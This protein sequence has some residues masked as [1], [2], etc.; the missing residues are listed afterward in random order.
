MWAG[1][2]DKGTLTLREKLRAAL[3]LLLAYPRLMVRYLHA[4][5][6]DDVLVLYP[7]VFEMFVVIP[8]AAGRGARVS[9][10]LFISPWDTLV[11]DRRAQ[12]A[13]HPM[14]LLLLACEWLASRF[15]DR[16][17]LDTAAHAR[18]FEIAMGLDR[19][20]V[21]NVPL[22]T[23]PAR[24]P[25]R[26]GVARAAAGNPAR[27]FRSPIRLLFYGQ[28]IPL[29]GL[30]TI[31][32]AAAIVESR[33]VRAEWRLV[34][35]GQEQAS[36][37]AH[38]ARL[39]VKSV[40]QLGWVDPS[41]LPAMI[42]DADV[43]LGIFGTSDKARTVVPNKAYELAAAQMPFISGDTPAMRE[44]VPAGG[45]PWVLLVPPGDAAALADCV[46]RLVT[47]G[48]VPAA[49]PLPVIGPR[50]RLRSAALIAIGT[51]VTP[52]IIVTMAPAAS[53]SRAPKL[54]CNPRS[55]GDRRP[56]FRS[57]RRR[58]GLGAVTAVPPPPRD[59]SRG[60]ATAPARTPARDRLRRREPSRRPA[61]GRLQVRGRGDQRRR[62]AR[63][64]L[65]SCR[66]FPPYRCTTALPRGEEGKFDVLFS[67]E[68]L[69]HIDDDV[70][71]LRSWLAL[72]KPGGRVLLSVPA[73]AKRWTATDCW[74]GH[75]RRYDRADFV[76]LAESAGIKVERCENYGFPLANLIEPINALAH[77]RE[78]KRRAVA[79]S[80]VDPAA[81]ADAVPEAATTATTATAATAASGVRRTMETR[82]YPLL[83]S[84]PG[85]LAMRA[86]IRM[87]RWFL[88]GELGNGFLLEGVKS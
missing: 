11:N 34:G 61:Q 40:T 38:I 41:A 62:R 71:A 17:F 33:G 74:A 77:G 1:V 26:D 43:G 4:P 45:H 39:Q 51:G 27:T 28:Y 10:D 56:A 63:S 22:G 82:L 64:R 75:V 37:T 87:Q 19:G 15:A 21:G 78:L 66:I 52:S 53:G 9:W 14:S 29:H 83:T 85:R 3:R 69:E 20:R 67:F 42:H 46:G 50:E 7:G 18:R 32:E 68:V 6:H 79:A 8:F 16:M 25:P 86:A 58:A 31:I 48:G 44:F 24:F 57:R 12:S 65:C 73:H 35:A 81:A 30:E 60:A 36:V 13:W 84:L 23:D 72:I 55:A 76:R 80:A 88:Q 2:R 49:P 70:G 47:A 54:P 59:D 5:P